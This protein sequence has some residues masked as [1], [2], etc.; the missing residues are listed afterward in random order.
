MWLGHRR[1]GIDVWEYNRAGKIIKRLQIHE[2]QIG[3]YVTALLPLPGGA[4]AVGTYGKGVSIVMLRGARDFWKHTSKGNKNAPA[5]SEPRGASPPTRRQLAALAGQLGEARKNSPAK[6][7]AV[8]SL[9]DDWRT[10]GSWLGRY[11]RY[12]ACLFGASMAVSKTIWT[13]DVV[14][15][16]RSER[17]YHSNFIGPHHFRREVAPGHMVVDTVRYWVGRARTT[18]PRALEL[19]SAFLR[20][21][22]S[23]LSVKPAAGRTDCCDDDHGEFYSSYWQGPDLYEFFDLPLGT[24]VISLYVWSD[25]GHQG[26]NRNRDYLFSVVPIPSSARTAWPGKGFLVKGP[27]G[28]VPPGTVPSASVRFV[29]EQKGVATSRAVMFECG[30]WKRFLVR[31]GGRFVLRIRRNYSLNTKLAGV[32][33]DTLQQHPAP[34]YFSKAGWKARKQVIRKRDFTL[35]AQLLSGAL[36]NQLSGSAHPAAVALALCQLVQTLEYRDPST[37]QGIGPILNTSLLRWVLSRYGTQPAGDAARLEEAEYY[38]DS[39]FRRWEATELSLGLPTSREMEQAVPVR[40]K[41]EDFRTWRQSAGYPISQPSCYCL[42]ALCSLSLL[43]RGYTPASAGLA[44]LSARV[45]LFLDNFF[46]FRQRSPG[47][48]CATPSSSGIGTALVPLSTQVATGRA[49]GAVPATT[50]PLQPVV[51]VVPWQLLPLL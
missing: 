39:L 40:W 35:R 37:W 32:M 10:Q 1:R 49:R 29:A 15:S 50:C 24:H 44:E 36:R 16:A 9:D 38:A 45:R 14:W 8:V 43:L 42:R 34:Y 28:F 7:P 48:S 2:P 27:M 26:E 25:D 41:E 11:G 4:M 19:P 13:P 20:S 23:A 47:C 21:L 31:G 18:N 30:V 46:A 51:R 22:V 17:V 33:V 12:W 5:I 3:N 6:S